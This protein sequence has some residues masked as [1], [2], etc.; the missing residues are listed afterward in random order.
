VKKKFLKLK[1]D[2]HIQKQILLNIKQLHSS[3]SE[4]EFQRK[5]KQCDE[6][7]P[8]RFKLYFFK[9]WINSINNLWQVYNSPYGFTSSNS[10]IE[11]F[12]ASVK[13]YTKRLIMDIFSA[14]EKVKD[15]CIYEANRLNEF[16]CKVTVNKKTLSSAKIIQKDLHKLSNDVFNYYSALSRKTYI[17]NT[18]QKVCSCVCFSKTMMCKHL[19][20][21]CLK[22][23][24]ELE[25]APIKLKKK[26]KKG[27]KRIIVDDS[28]DEVNQEDSGS[29][30]EPIRPSTTSK[31]RAIIDSDSDEHDEPSTMMNLQ[32][33]E[34][35][36][37]KP[38]GRGRPPGS[39]NKN[40]NQNKN[41]RKAA[42]ALKL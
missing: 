29:D 15:I 33:D 7:W 4:T 30:D 10:T 26:P 9:V 21:A 16:S 5:L 31:P 20:A 42:K 32:H 34:P 36:T 17:I 41:S 12:N 8:K 27:R 14:F 11:S 13:R 23:C 3:M 2:K 18:T 37:S 6:T 19:V 1:I 24:V 40:S 28:D 25:G 35:S 39:K 38:R 22:N